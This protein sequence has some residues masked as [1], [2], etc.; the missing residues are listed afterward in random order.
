METWDSAK[1]V[2]HSMYSG[3][4]VAFWSGINEICISMMGVTGHGKSSFI[5]ILDSASPRNLVP[6]ILRYNGHTIC[7]IDTPGFDDTDKSDAEKIQCISSW[8][9]ECYNHTH[10]LAGT[11]YLHKG[12]D[13]R[14]NL[15][16]VCSEVCNPNDGHVRTALR[17]TLWE[18][19]QCLVP[20]DYITE[21]F[22]E[23]FHSVLSCSRG[24]DSNF[25]GTD[26]W[27]DRMRHIHEHL[28]RLQ[29]DDMSSVSTNDQESLFDY[30]PSEGYTSKTVGSGSIQQELTDTNIEHMLAVLKTERGK[31][32]EELRGLDATLKTIDELANCRH[33]RCGNC[34]H[35]RCGDCPHMVRSG[36]HE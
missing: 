30:P 10:I 20:I 14:G 19:H 27:N 12:S 5:R 9:A 11:M 17:S 24:T 31:C 32:L 18:C 28:Y 16:T 25:E 4:H 7:L 33:P 13:K 36:V 23:Q 3:E 22:C 1:Q 6:S 34:K 26:H 8:L 2:L 21:K 35:P 15:A 29:E